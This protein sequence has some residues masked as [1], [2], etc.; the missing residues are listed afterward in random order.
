MLESKNAEYPVGSHWLCSF[1]WRSHTVI[2]PADT[3]Y[4]IKKLP[5]F[6]D[7]PLSLALGTVG[8]PG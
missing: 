2:T 3:E 6:G 7:N 4:E 1:G 5:D 8:L